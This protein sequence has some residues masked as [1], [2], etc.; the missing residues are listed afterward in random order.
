[1]FF[2]WISI[3][4]QD[5]DGSIT[6]DIKFPTNRIDVC[7]SSIFSSLLMACS[8]CPANS[9]PSSDILDGEGNFVECVCSY[10]Y[11]SSTGNAPCTKCATSTASYRDRTG[12]GLCGNGTVGRS[13]GLCLCSSA[14]EVLVDMDPAGNRLTEIDPAGNR[15]TEIEC[16]S[17]PTGTMVVVED[18]TIAGKKYFADLWSCQ[19]CPDPLMAMAFSSDS[20]VCTCPTSYTLVGDTTIGPQSCVL[21]STI[22]A[23]SSE[24]TTLST[25]SFKNG[26]TVTS[27]TIKH[28]LLVAISECANLVE[29]VSSNMNA[30]QVLANLCV[31]TQYDDSAG[32]VCDSFNAIASTRSVYLYANW[33]V[34]LPWLTYG[35]ATASQICEDRGYTSRV[36]LNEGL[37]KFYVAKYS[38]NGTWMGLT[39]LGTTFS[40]C[41]MNPPFSN[42]GGGRGADTRFEIFAASRKTVYKCQMS[43]LLDHNSVD[44]Y[45]YE[46]FLAD[47]A[48][49]LY[50]VPVRIVNLQQSDGL[51]NSLQP[52]N[53]LCD[54]DD[55]LVRRFYLTDIVTGIEDSSTRFQNSGRL[56]PTVLRFASTISIAVS[57]ISTPTPKLYA[58]VLTIEYDEMYSSD[59]GTYSTMPYTVDGQ[60]YKPMDAF[61]AYVRQFFIA[62]MVFVGMLFFLR[63]SNWS[64]RNTRSVSQMTTT[65][66][67][68][69]LNLVALSKILLLAM[70]SWVVIF[71]PFL[72]LLC[73]YLFVFFKIQ[74]YPSVLLPPVDDIYSTTSPYF[75][76]TATLHVLAFF[77][78]AYVL[79]L[80]FKQSYADTFFIDW[81]PVSAKTDGGGG[82]VSV[83][84]SVLVAN[85]WAEILTLRRTDIRFTM[86]FIIFLYY[87]KALQYDAAQQP[88]LNNKSEADINPI[89]RFATSVWWWLLFS[90]G[91]YYFNYLIY[92]RFF[93]EPPEQVFVDLCTIAKISILALDEEYHGYYLHCRSPHQFADGTMIELLDMLQ[94][95][96]AGLTVDRSLDGAPKDVQTFEVFMSAEWRQ[97]FDKS[98]AVL[99]HPASMTDLLHQGRRGRQA[100]GMIRFDQFRYVH[101]LALSSFCVLYVRSA[102]CPGIQK[103]PQCWVGGLLVPANVALKLGR[104]LHCFCS[105]LSTTILVGLG[106]AELFANQLTLNRCSAFR[107]ILQLRNRCVCSSPIGS[108]ILRS[109]RS[110]ALRAT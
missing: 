108:I 45:F 75:M 10:G 73:W 22:S 60:Y 33:M 66:N 16:L 107:R 55:V 104:K 9:E 43:T 42:E 84:R 81:E 19:T 89:L 36:L 44:Q 99:K 93:S 86:L 68:G 91:Q 80:V 88:D 56:A 11:F 17:C 98:F 24:L 5:V 4:V 79:F 31:L 78:L 30:C 58:P 49:S 27:A 41:S 51:H 102:E 106:F 46:L 28:Y 32:G 82:R 87:A 85:E 14:H 13:E 83:W 70:H 52:S 105:S 37:L 62:G 1:M 40:Y 69:D 34:D 20:Y 61:F 25:I 63:Y 65:T 53:T 2:F 76:Y 57:L 67:L 3:F 48:G 100:P 92:H 8:G 23:Y 59:I 94:K 21:T 38:M 109:L 26:Q 71:F 29:G 77:Q 97:A 64:K 74:K 47:K 103:R 12:C 90:A 18:T 72:V 54:T 95:E 6:G 7:P 50:P 101:M 110:W 96:E 15:L 35:T 39:E